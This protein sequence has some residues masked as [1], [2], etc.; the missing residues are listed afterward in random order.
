MLLMN[1]DVL[2]TYAYIEINIFVTK[3]C[4]LVDTFLR[5]VS[6]K[7]HNIVCQKLNPNIPHLLPLSSPLGAHMEVVN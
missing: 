3:L 5:N 6:T 2:D 1:S 4:G 7:L